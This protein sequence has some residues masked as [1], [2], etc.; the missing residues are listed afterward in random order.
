MI[1]ENKDI[2]GESTVAKERAWIFHLKDRIIF[3]NS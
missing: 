2:A 3:F 1:I